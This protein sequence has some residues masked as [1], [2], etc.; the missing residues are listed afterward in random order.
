MH[1][2]LVR[3][4]LASLTLFAVLAA[5]T[6]AFAGPPLLCHPFDIGTAKSLPWDGARSWFEG[7]PRFDVKTLVAETE[8]LLTPSTP[9]IVRMET[10]RRA[11]IYASRDK[12]I[13]SALLTS[14]TTR[15]RASEQKGH[16]DALAF[17]DAAYLT[18]A[19]R[20]V[21]MLE[22][23]AEFRESAPAMRALVAGADAYG[24]ISKS[25]ASKPGDPA[26]EFA[27]A[28][29]AADSRHEAYQRHA[30]NARAGAKTDALLAKNI[31]HVS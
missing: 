14:L 23:M 11:A 10:L 6:P 30:A 21:G 27:A 22:Q 1:C 13:A 4:R 2:T 31:G 17:H 5:A 3:S 15:A 29:I 12:A 16:P 7:D 9:V 8:A 18:G 24:L 28:L 19:L 20:E 25:L 26:L